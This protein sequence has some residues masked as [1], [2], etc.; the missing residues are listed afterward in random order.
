MI[1]ANM[2]GASIIAVGV[3]LHITLFV[4]SM[5]HYITGLKMKGC[6]TLANVSIPI[7]Q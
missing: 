7:V 3:M 4:D 6:Y 1:L 2:R 5:Q